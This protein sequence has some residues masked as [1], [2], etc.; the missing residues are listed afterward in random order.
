MKLMSY[1]SKLKKNDIK[2]KEN[3]WS[4]YFFFII[5]DVL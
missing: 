2:Q 5:R 1:D 4:Y 3:K